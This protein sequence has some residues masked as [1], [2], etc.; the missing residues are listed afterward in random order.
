MSHAADGADLPFSLIQFYATAPY[1][2]GYLPDR[3]ARSR[4]AAPPHLID[5]AIYSRLVQAGFRR[6]GQFIYRPCCDGCEA[7]VPVRLPVERLVP[8]RSQRRALKTLETLVARPAPLLFDEAHY[9]LYRR[10]LRVRHPGGGM[11]GDSREQY[12]R[13]VLDSP[14]DSRLCEF[15]D[16]DTLRM[17]CLVDLLDDGLSS[18]YTFYDPDLPHLSLGTACILWQAAL[19]RSLGLPYLY[20][21]YWIAAS[22]KMAYKTNFHPIEA[23]L[24]GLW[25]ELSGKEIAAAQETV[26]RAANTA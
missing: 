2:C 25:R 22:P 8:T 19:C 6:G 11:D 3:R 7:C 9:A 10:Y 16:E 23:Y 20:L 18:I 4:V 21:G 1:P 26:R 13:F 5:E 24:D 15:W 12:A 14:V 17:V